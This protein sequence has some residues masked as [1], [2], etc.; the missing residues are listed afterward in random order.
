MQCDPAFVEKEQCH[1]EEPNGSSP[2]STYPKST[3]SPPLL[4]MADNKYS[5]SDHEQ[6]EE[7]V[8]EDSESSDETD[9]A[10]EI[11]QCKKYLVFE[12]GL[13]KLFS[14]SPHCTGPITIQLIQLMFASVKYKSKM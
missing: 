5:D 10:M 1:N 7:S 8:S 12:S 9:V 3:V 14:V 4:D 13:E 2:L 11:I 6:H